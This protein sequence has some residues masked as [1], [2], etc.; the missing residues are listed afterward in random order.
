MHLSIWELTI[1][2]NQCLWSENYFSLEKVVIPKDT[3]AKDTT[4]EA[5]KELQRGVHP[6]FWSSIM[7]G[8][9]II[10]NYHGI[11]IIVISR[12][13]LLLLLLLLLRYQ[14]IYLCGVE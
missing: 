4:A 2:I 11:I 14:I 7:P 5:K 13:F 9:F 3:I 6:S 12:I 8:S 1:M 10:N